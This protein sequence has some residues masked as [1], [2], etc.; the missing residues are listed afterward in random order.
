MSHPAITPAVLQS[1]SFAAPRIAPSGV[2][3]PVTSR[4][5]Q[6]PAQREMPDRKSRIFQG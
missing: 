6:R 2:V 3:S 1:P 5:S 4:A